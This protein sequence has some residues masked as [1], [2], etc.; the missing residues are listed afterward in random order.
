MNSFYNYLRQFCLVAFLLITSGLSL[1]TSA[2]I[3]GINNIC[4]G[5][6]TTYSD[7][8]PGGTW[9]MTNPSRA[10]IDYY[11]GTVTAYTAG[12]DTIIYTVGAVSTIKPIL[13]HPVPLSIVGPFTVCGGTVAPFTDATS[14]GTWSSSSPAIAT[15][16]AGTGN[17]SGLAAG[18]LVLS[19]TL[20]STGCYVTFPI[21]VT[22]LPDALIGCDNVG[23][24]DSLTFYGLNPYAGVGTDTSIAIFDPASTK[25]IGVAPGITPVEVIDYTTGCAISQRMVTVTAVPGILP[26]AGN[27]VLCAGNTILLGDSVSG[28]TWS[29][30]TPSI[31]S[32]SS[33]G[34]VTAVSGGV[35]IISYSV[36]GYTCN[37]PFAVN[38]LPTPVTGP[39]N[40]CTGDTIILN[41]TAASYRY[42]TFINYGFWVDHSPYITYTTG[43]YQAGMF[44]TIDS[45]IAYVA[46]NIMPGTG[47]IMGIS[48][49]TP[50]ISF[51]DQYT[52]CQVTL[53]ITVNANPS[54]ITGLSYFHCPG[55]GT[56]LYSDATSGGSW[57]T[58]DPSVAT[59]GASTGMLSA[60]SSGT[61]N[62]TYT[63]PDGCLSTTSV[64]DVLPLTAVSGA[65]AIC[66]GAS[67]TLS[68]FPTCTWTSSNP[69]IAT[70]GAATGYLT[71]VSSGVA[72]INATM[73]AGCNVARVVTIN[74]T[75]GPISGSS[76]VCVGDVIDLSSLVA[77]TWNSLS[78]AIATADPLSG[79]VS[80]VSS[81]V[82][83]IV[84]TNALGC[85]STKTVTV[86]LSP[87]TGP[88]TGPTMV[89]QGSV[90]ALSDSVT[91]G[92]YSSSLPGITTVSGTGVVTGIAAGVATISYSVSTLC[93]TAIALQSVTVN[94]LPV[95]G[96]LSGLSTVC[97]GAS[98]TIAA[99]DTGGVWTEANTHLTGS[100]GV[101]T[102]ASAGTDTVFYSVTNI[103]GTAATSKIITINPLP[104]VAPITGA[105]TVCIA[106]S[107]TLSDAA[108]GGSWSST[109][110]ASVSGGTTTG[111]SA[112][113]AII[114]Y[115]SLTPCGSLSAT[116]TIT[117]NPLP[118]A[119]VIAGSANV[120]TGSSII[121][122]DTTS[123]GLWSSSN[124]N[125]TVAG[126]TVSGITSGLD[127][128][129]YSVS[130]ICGTAKTIQ[131][132]SVN[133]LP[134]VYSI[135]GS[136]NY[137][138]GSTGAD[139]NMAT[140]QIWTNYLLYKDSISTGVTVAGTGGPIDFGM[141]TEGKYTIRAVSTL[142]GCEN[143][144]TGFDTVSIAP[145]VVP[146]VT[147]TSNPGT[148]IGVGT[149]DTLTAN[150]TGGG[151]SPTYQWNLN[152]SDIYGATSS[153]YYSNTFYNGDSVSCF[154]TSNAE[155]GTSNTGHVFISTYAS[156][157]KNI[158]TT[159]DITLFPNPNKGTF[160][161]NYSS[162]TTE[163]I[164]IVINNITGEKVMELTTTSNKQ[165]NIKLD[166]PP[167]IYFLTAI[168]AKGR[169]V[170]KITVE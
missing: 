7:A 113:T 136:G 160:T 169:Y 64:T 133:P 152:G 116:K 32:V 55:G 163:E 10:F 140:S 57:T 62:V 30:S 130:N 23:V 48:A 36:G 28:G 166:T 22:P 21:S 44:S 109:S 142:S 54:P 119:G 20:T 6:P 103:C 5:A 26:I 70:I 90:I 45:T 101:L 85:T 126:G 40:V 158:G 127:T 71:G 18:T 3:T 96:S 134:S 112:G 95:S 25:I 124:S 41:S 84:L 50:V 79:I 100:A 83:S 167:G 135:T 11:S 150:V 77:G 68:W 88:L 139:I 72:I 16:D 37:E 4:V 115:T 149:Y 78:P 74:A 82:A 117:I 76:V 47:Y 38:S 66:P 168:S 14:G 157:V 13:I 132:I 49:G 87:V 69:S 43:P 52:N 80:G 56:T 97:Q 118:Y 154:V 98:I 8:T 59:I 27:N 63:M 170:M 138:A 81:G 156:G 148:H 51:T 91:G 94:P 92:L 125:A 145:T 143:G 67:D 1:Q 53:P 34:L 24:A 137:C 114:S 144:M 73:G 110:Y 106:S 89:C 29:S 39:T 165:I 129:G 19:Y 104:A 17:V 164:Q 111:I 107:I 128:I 162:G 102:G 61:V 161:F 155:C 58:S 121:I 122:T 60:T 75:P 147:I 123:G 105:S 131:I 46:L 99:A 146:T 42:G 33:T 12:L 93:A 141:F 9:S 159:N 151:S 108:P 120:C 35:A 31:V 65:N 2:Q 153:V 86:D 15:I